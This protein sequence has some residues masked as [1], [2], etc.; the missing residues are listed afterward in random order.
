[1]KVL[2]GSLLGFFVVFFIAILGTLF[3]AITGWL[4]G[5]AFSDS[6][7]GVLSS[8]HVYNVTMWQFGAFLGF[9]GG[10]FRQVAT[11]NSQS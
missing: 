7:L 6:V 4:V 9:V 11:F 8:L 10:F 1:M 5:L 3:G 2:L